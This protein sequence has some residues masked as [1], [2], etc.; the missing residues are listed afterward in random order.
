MIDYKMNTFMAVCKT[1][2]FTQ[3]SK[4]LNITQPAV[5]NHIKAIEE[6]YGIDLFRFQGKKVIL[7][8]E[9]RLLL[10]LIS[11]MTNDIEHFKDYLSHNRSKIRLNF[12]TTLSIGEYVMSPI[13]TKII[14]KESELSLRMVVENT[15]KLLELL[16]TGK[17][18]FA[19]I[20]GYFKI[21]SYQSKVF[22]KD[23]LIPVCSKN[24]MDKDNVEVKEI[25]DNWLFIR[26]EGSGTREVLD[27]T[28]RGMNYSIDDFKNISEIGNLNTIKALVEN[29]LGISFLYESVVE[30]E[31]KN[32]NLREILLTD[33]RAE[34][35]FTFLWKE[36]SFYSDYY[37]N[38]FEIL[39]GE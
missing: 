7:T 39:K 37:E 15:Q 35:D 18:D 9:G 3:A 23:R 29:G 34:H 1:L 4:E 26:E 36:G 12:G 17:I 16:D 30:K 6:E 8:E 13:L 38:L 28:L 24:Y 11:S 2:N 25:F 10:N 21:N 14:S 22:K 20:E 32:G 27:R 33:F 5:S 19:I 31:I